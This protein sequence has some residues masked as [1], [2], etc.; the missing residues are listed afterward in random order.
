MAA[1]TPTTAGGAEDA[2]AAEAAQAVTGHE[3][4]T[5]TTEAAGH[6]EG[7]GGLPQFRF[8]YW[9]GQ[10]V[11]L[12]FTFAILYFLMAKVFIPRLRRIQETRAQTIAEAVEQARKVKAEADAQAT[13]AEAEIHE[14]RAQARR[15]AADAR[16]K[17]AADLAASQAAE[18]QR[19]QAELAQA[20]ERIRA[21]RD[22]AMTSVGAIAAET[23]E[24][25]VAKLTGVAPS[26]A[27][28]DAAIAQRT[29]EG[30]A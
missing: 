15:T 5:A 30:A 20:E 4:T 16:A 27:D 17:A 7:G 14:A 10:I 25:M 12:L 1:E 9:G 21:T 23:A 11:W 8:E 28:L 3:A 19:L 2:P 13:A 22:Q 26:R 18:D 24:A 6:G 29:P